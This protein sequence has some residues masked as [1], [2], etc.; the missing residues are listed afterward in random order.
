M[1]AFQDPRYNGKLSSADSVTIFVRYSQCFQHCP[2][3]SGDGAYETSSYLPHVV[4][5]SPDCP[6][7]CLVFAE[8]KATTVLLDPS[9]YIFGIEPLTFDRQASNVN[10][11][12]LVWGLGT[13]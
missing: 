6:L 12:F 4:I 2:H 9:S 13:S 7:G 5:R 11:P 3:S 1:K 8:L 10:E